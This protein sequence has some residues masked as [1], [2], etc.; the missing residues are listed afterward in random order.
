MSDA[1]P[2]DAYIEKAMGENCLWLPNAG[3]TSF[4]VEAQGSDGISVPQSMRSPAANKLLLVGAV[5]G[6]ALDRVYLPS[7]SLVWA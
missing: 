6:A 3:G 5:L 7:R 4:L 1:W 2:V